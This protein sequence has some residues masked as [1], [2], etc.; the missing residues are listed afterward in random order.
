MNSM[1]RLAGCASFLGLF[2]VGAYA[3]CPVVLEDAG[4]DI[5]EWIRCRRTFDSETERGEE[6]S[7]RR[8][9]AVERHL[10]KNQIARD[11][12]AGK[13]SLAEAADR[14]GEL[15]H[16]PRRMREL[17]RLYQGSATDEEIMGRHVIDWACT[18]QE[19]E[20]ARVDAL[21]ARLEKELQEYLHNAQN[22]Q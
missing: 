20:P 9:F 11:L 14:F 10:A 22:R 15:P 1:L 2:F 8:Q 4:L 18:L 16:P 13:L 19:N 5:A 12:I 17:L 3:F 6:L 21:R 7:Q